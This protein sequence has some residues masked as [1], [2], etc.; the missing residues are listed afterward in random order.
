M[1]PLAVMYGVVC[2]VFPLGDTFKALGRQRLM[3]AVNAIALPV[4]SWRCCSRRPRD[5]RGRMEPGV[6]TVARASSGSC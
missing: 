4:R 3:V 2:I 6:V 5:R 1:Q